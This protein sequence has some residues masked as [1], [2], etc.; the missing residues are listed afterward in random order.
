MFNEIKISKKVD[1]IVDNT[2]TVLGLKGLEIVAN[3][4]KMRDN[5]IKF[6]ELGEKML[7]E[8][9]G[10]TVEIKGLTVPQIKEKLRQARICWLKEYLS[11]E[12]E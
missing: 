12:K 1:F 10:N 5:R 8:V 9:N 3:C 6:S 11:Q 7:N 2:K 4:D